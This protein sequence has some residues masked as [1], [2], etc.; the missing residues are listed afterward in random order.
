MTAKGNLLYSD[1]HWCCIMFHCKTSPYLHN[2]GKVDNYT[3]WQSHQRQLAHNGDEGY[4][5]MVYGSRTHTRKIIFISPKIETN[6]IFT[7]LQQ[8]PEIEKTIG[9]EVLLSLTF[10]DVN[11]EWI[12]LLCA[13]VNHLLD[14][15]NLINN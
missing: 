2:R 10:R 14:M 3:K 4:A 7:N 15:Y 13:Q 6:V 11:S 8:T 1:S 12:Y 5:F 9:E